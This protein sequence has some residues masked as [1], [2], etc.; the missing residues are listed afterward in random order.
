M[1]DL[2]REK[3]ILRRRT[4]RIDGHSTSVSLEDVFW[5]QF[6]QIAEARG[7]KLGALAA[8]IKAAIGPHA[9]LSSGVRCFVLEQTRTQA[10]P[11]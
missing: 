1:T 7:M 3:P 8:Q 6:K 4:M 10:L 2:L 11:Y 5:E 9:N